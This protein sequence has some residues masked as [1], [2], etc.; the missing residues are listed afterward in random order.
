MKI[1][2]VGMGHQ[3]LVVAACLAEH[4]HQVVGVDRVPELVARLNAAEIDIYEPGLEELIARNLE[5]ER[6]SFTTDF[7]V[8]VSGSLLSFICVHAPTTDTGAI[9]AQP[10]LDVAAEIME[11]RKEYTII[12][13]RCAVPPGTAARIRAHLEAAGHSHFDVVV[14]P[15]FLKRGN[16][17]D[18]FLRPDRVVAGCNGVRMQEIMK[19]LF[20]P[21]LRTG[22]PFIAMLPESA[23]F[24]RYAMSAMLSARISLM[25]ELAELAVRYKADMGEVREGLAADERIG[26]TF[27][28]PGLGFGGAGLTKD[29][30]SLRH[31][32]EAAGIP[33]ELVQGIQN[34]NERRQQGFL[35]C[36][37]IHYG[38]ALAGKRLAVWGASFKPRTND[39]THAPSLRIIDG[40][41]A[42]GAAIV[43]YDPAADAAIAQ[44]YAGRVQTAEKFYQALEGVDGLIICTE[45]NTFRR[46]D[47]DR[48]KGLMRQPVI[49]DG[50]NLYNPRL[51]AQEGFTYYSIGRETAAPTQS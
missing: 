20:S 17:L 2:V 46:P 22:K 16:A 27:L 38:A 44:H 21:F 48:M 14:N 7:G 1:A 33:V 10:V 39:I 5:E 6:L 29:L 26:S 3:G 15:D 49:F 36:I 30:A 31:L 47:F 34:V 32:A 25:N 42:A 11:H 51:L 4:G 13:N 8:A 37:K 23:E 35:E 9:D 28:F 43:V 12:V 45:W 50:R 40:L 18:D 19:E 41:L 24:L